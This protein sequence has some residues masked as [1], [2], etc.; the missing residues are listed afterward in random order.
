MRVIGLS[1]ASGAGKTTL[2]ERIIP[3]LRARG[4]SVSTVKHAHHGFDLD[5]PGKDSWRHRAAGAAQVL[6]ASGARWA[7]L[8]ELG[9]APEPPLPALLDRLDPVDLV[10]VEGFRGGPHPRIEVRRAA[11]GAPWRWPSDPLVRAVAS[12]T[13][14]P[15]G[16]PEWLP[17]ADA[18]R[19][20]AAA[21]RL[22]LPRAAL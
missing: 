3:L 7:L 2:I 13:P 9:G 1:G 14:P 21:W 4:L 5:R 19:V 12:D 18:P 11:T 6:V 15:D 17:L 20:A 16:A 10:L 22:A 8:S